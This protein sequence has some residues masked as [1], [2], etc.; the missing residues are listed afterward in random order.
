M[1]RERIL[2][3]DDEEASRTGL[4]ELLTQWGYEV[5]EAGSGTEAWEKVTTFRP[6]VIIADLVMPNGDGMSLLRQL[7]EDL[8]AISVIMLTGQGTIEAAVEAIKE[9]AY[10]FLTKPVDLDRLRLILTKALEREDALTEILALRR[11][12]RHLGRYGSLVGNTPAMREVYRLIELAAP[13]DAPVLIWGESG[14]GKELV[15]QTVHALSLRQKE[16]FFPINCSAIPETLLESEFFGHEKGAFTG[17]VERRVGCFELADHGTLF[18]DEIAEMHPGTQAKLLR[19]LQEGYLRRLGGRA[20]IRVDVR[21]V[22]AT[23]K[24][25]AQAVAKGELREDLYYRLNVFVIH[26]PP[27]RERVEDIPLLVQS[28]IEEFA[29]KNQKKVVSVDEEAL[30]IL[31]SHLWPGSVRELR[32]VMERA[33]IVCPGDLITPAHLPPTLLESVRGGDGRPATITIPVG[34]TVDEAERELILR[35]LEQTGGNKTRAAAI[36]GV[37]LKTLHNKLKRYTA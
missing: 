20:E 23:N 17:A 33:V 10:D 28:F 5:E 3:A 29:T 1:S 18:L 4:R 16:H 36:L 8:P 32:N 30:K 15:A 31:T 13:T 12:L 37:S 35:T 14:T 22:A 24:D 6:A 25:P 2:V 19:V 9:G 21:V 27:L 26:L 7:K 11:Q 34:T